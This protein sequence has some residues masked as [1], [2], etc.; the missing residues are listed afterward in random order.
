MNAHTQYYASIFRP[1][2]VGG[3]SKFT[4]LHIVATKLYQPSYT[5]VKFRWYAHLGGHVG[6]A[7][8]QHSWVVLYR[9]CDVSTLP[10]T[11]SE[12][13]R[14]PS[15]DYEKCIA[16][17]S[18]VKHATLGLHAWSL[19]WFIYSIKYGLCVINGIPLT[20]MIR[21]FIWKRICLI[22]LCMHWLRG[23]KC[24]SCNL[25]DWG[26]KLLISFSSSI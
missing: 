18:I 1:H 15:G 8:S 24:F 9:L 12:G 19:Y 6:S 21:R 10:N 13:P 5:A 11:G 16:D 4:Q 7:C 26:Y 25:I 3:G 20:P 22:L 14:P 23:E 17:E 2:K